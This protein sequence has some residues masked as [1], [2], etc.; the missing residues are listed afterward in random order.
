LTGATRFLNSFRS[1]SIGCIGTGITAELTIAQEENIPY[2]LL[3]GRHDNSCKK[4]KH[5][6]SNDA[7]YNWTWDNLEAL[8]GGAR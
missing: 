3:R 2:F 7:M 6:Y 4:P 8:L 1:K 5:A